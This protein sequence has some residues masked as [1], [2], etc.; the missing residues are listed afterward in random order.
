MDPSSPADKNG[1]NYLHIL[2]L[3]LVLSD[4]ESNDKTQRDS[5]A[6]VDDEHSHKMNLQFDASN[7]FRTYRE[8]K[9]DYETII[10]SVKTEAQIIQRLFNEYET[11]S[12]EETK[13]IVLQDLAEYLHQFDNAVDFANSGNLS[14]LVQELPDVPLPRKVYIARCLSSA[15]QGYVCCRS[16][17]LI[18]TTWYFFLVSY[19]NAL[20]TH[21]ALGS[22]G[23]AE[24]GKRGCIRLPN[25]CLSPP[26]KWVSSVQGRLPPFD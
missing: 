3:E 12:S 24:D 6:T 19:L 7:K 21:S 13:N 4:I 26:K 16:L 17:Q 2:L 9:K 25:S 23:S 14:K 10:S 22:D 1:I 8:L 20:R 18:K 5:P 15:L 11:S